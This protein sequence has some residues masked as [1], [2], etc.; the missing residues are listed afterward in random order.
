MSYNAVRLNNDQ[1]NEVGNS[2]WELVSHI[3]TD[4]EHDYIF[5][6]PKLKIPEPSLDDE[7][8]EIIIGTDFAPK[9]S[10]LS[11]NL[12]DASFDDGTH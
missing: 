6:R 8:G 7:P 5:K 9:P 3:I 1:L 2:G 11:H 10:K 4:G 12:C